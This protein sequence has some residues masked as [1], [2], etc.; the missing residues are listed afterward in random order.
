MRELGLRSLPIFESGKREESW[1][2]GVVLTSALKR[3]TAFGERGGAACLSSFM[4]RTR[5][6]HAPPAAPEKTICELSMPRMREFSKSQSRAVRASSS[7]SM[8]PVLCF[9]AM[10]VSK[11]METAPRE[12]KWWQWGTNW[13]TMAASQKPPWKKMTA[14]RGEDEALVG[15]KTWA[16]RSPPSRVA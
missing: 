13:V 14:G 3:M 5:A 11:A 9:E 10:R 15:A 4:A 8:G 12:A 7:A 6:S 16:R 1:P 2:F